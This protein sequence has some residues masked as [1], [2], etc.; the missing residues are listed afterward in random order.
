MMQANNPNIVELDG[1]S[2][3]MAVAHDII[4]RKMRAALA[5]AARERIRK[6][7]GV[8]E[9]SLASGKPIY[10]INTGFGKLAEVRIDADHLD[11]LQKKI[12]LSHACGV[13]EPLGEQDVRAILLTKANTLAKGYSGVRIEVVELLLDMLNANILPLI[14]KKGSVGASGDLAPLAHLAMAAIG[15]GDVLYQGAR[16][17]SRR[18]LADCGLEALQLQ[19]KEGL[20]LLNGTHFMVG[21]G[22]QNLRYAGTM[23]IAADII[24][25]MTAEAALCTPAA[26]DARI[27]AA[28]GHGGQIAS[29]QRL[30]RMMQHSE[31]RD[32]H[33][34]CDRVQDPYSVRCMPQVHGAIQDNLAH[35]QSVVATELNAATDNPLVFLEEQEI[36][37]GGNFHGHPIATV[38]DL[39][40]L[41][42]AQLG[43]ISER[44]IAMLM[45]SNISTLPAFLIKHSGLNSGFMIAHV[46]AASLVSENKVLS[47]PASV[48]S[49]PTSANKEDYV[50]MGALAAVKAREVVENTARVLGIELLAACQAIELRKPLQPGPAAAH[51]LQLVRKKVPMLEQDRFM[52]DE[53]ESAAELVLSGEL[54]EKMQKF[55][56]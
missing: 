16:M 26:F 8:I 49:I 38:M 3:T 45:D 15:E 50:S 32:S 55:L 21:V 2:L 41:I 25:A 52:A 24:G 31:I 5:P 9:K 28:R 20:A 18:A 27:H 11:A 36:L 17:S 7:R 13:G 40:A 35:V 29:A 10:G 1:N 33:L 4:D 22:I 42:M 19:A 6:A 51:A 14:P 37:S 53:I 48:D 54:T 23:A 34:E 43:N 46:A 47:H 44:R 39:L 56:T 30:Q 12:V